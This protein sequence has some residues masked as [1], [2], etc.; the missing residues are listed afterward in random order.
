MGEK[1]CTSRSR[2]ENA[3]KCD[4]C[5]SRRQQQIAGVAEAI[6]QQYG[7][8]T[9]TVIKPHDNTAAAVK[10]VHASFMRR[11]LAPAGIWTIETGELFG[12][13]HLNILSPRPQEARWRGCDTYSELLR[14]TARDA[15]AYI[16]KR[17]GMPPVEQ[18]PGRLYGSF[19]QIGE[20]LATQERVPVV[21]AAMLEVVISAARGAEPM[22]DKR[23]FAREQDWSRLDKSK[24]T[25]YNPEFPHEC[26]P[27]L[28]LESGTA[29]A[30]TLEQRRELM[31][32]HLP[33]LYAAIGR[34]KQ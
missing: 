27:P 7:P 18:Y 4:Y 30:S 32:K 20:I 13:L 2:C 16:A 1:T 28:L 5:A 21:Q 25:F 6:E 11:A 31:R 24:P 8:L 33:N 12:G 26:N 14:T 22:P 10:A 17:S 29:P 3:R 34:G 15:G 19:G 23:V 9:M